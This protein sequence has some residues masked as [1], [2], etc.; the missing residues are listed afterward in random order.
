MQ[1]IILG[2]GTSVFHPQRAAAAF[3]VQTEQGSLLLDC[4]ADAPHRMAQEALDWP[5]LDAIWI[6]HLHLDHCGGLASLLFGMKHAP[7]TQSRRKPLQIFGC[8]GTKKL[9]AAINDAHDYK[10]SELPFPLDLTEVSANDSS[11]P[12]EILSGLT[13]TIV[14][15]PHRPESLALK[16]A[17]DRG[18]T[19]VYSSDT[20]FSEE[21]ARFAR[22]ADLF[23]LECS[24]YRNKPLQTHLELADAMSISAIAEPR[25]VVL[26]HLYPEWDGV[27]LEGEAR[28]LWPGKTVAAYDGLRIEA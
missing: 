13:A 12:F 2:S 5:N 25:K 18:T 22:H 15:T 3:W 14:S 21:V 27:D 1:L 4:S 9:L 19:I 20:G 16:L 24:F 28:K 7:Q 6:S 23:L 10:L 26:T 11:S 8:A 17:D